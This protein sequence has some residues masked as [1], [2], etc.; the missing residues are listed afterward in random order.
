MNS[1]TG[2]QRR[3]R[4]R[5]LWRLSTEGQ[6]NSAARVPRHVRQGRMQQDASQKRWIIIRLYP[7][8]AGCSP[9][10]A[11]C[12]HITDDAAGCI[13]AQT[14][15]NIHNIAHHRRLQPSGAPAFGVL[16]D[17]N[18]LGIHRAREIR[19]KMKMTG[20]DG[21]GNS[22]GAIRDSQHARALRR[23]L[24]RLSIPT[25]TTQIGR[26]RDCCTAISAGGLSSL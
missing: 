23:N 25:D 8:A 14:H 9:C 15:D 16:V 1:N 17:R 21:A 13:M 24:W 5:S 11:R 10:A 22:T 4:W 19:A 7:N 3:S 2:R 18:F 26:G 20:R 12:I 6:S